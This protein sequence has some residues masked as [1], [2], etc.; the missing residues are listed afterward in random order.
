MNGGEGRDRAIAQAFRSGSA[1]RSAVNY[2]VARFVQRET[3]RLPE[4]VEEVSDD[5][6]LA[7]CDLTIRYTGVVQQN[8]VAFAEHRK[9]KKVSAK[10]VKLCARKS[11]EL[12]S[13]LEDM[14]SS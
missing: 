7:L 13:H 2:Q 1:L 3:P 12:V 10:D 4:G 9:G 5:A 11:Q 6:L 8:L 14:E